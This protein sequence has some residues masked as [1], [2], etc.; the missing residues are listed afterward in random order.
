MSILFINSSPNHNGNTAKL[1]R[2]LLAGHDYQTL[3]LADY[4]LYAYGQNFADDQLDDV[5]TEVAKAA[6][7][8]IGSP[9]Y[10]HNLNGLLRNFLDRQYGR[11]APEFAG[12]RLFFL[13]QGQAP[14]PEILAAGEYTLSRFS[15]YYDMDYMG[16]AHNASEAK[17]IA[18][19]V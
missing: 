14:T 11:V 16:M 9:V 6:T 10:W 17:K 15:S 1:A 2:V 12:K 7:I 13:F 3:D 19:E 8:V 4:K 5:M 18:K